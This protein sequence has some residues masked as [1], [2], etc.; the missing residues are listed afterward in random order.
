MNELMHQTRLAHARFADDRHHLTVTLAG[1]LLDAMNLLQ[2]DIAA[3][4]AR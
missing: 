3:N 4:E 2:L 1:K